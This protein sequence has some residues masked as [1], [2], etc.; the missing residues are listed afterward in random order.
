MVTSTNTTTYKKG[1]FYEINLN[2]LLADPRQPRK[3]MDAQG[4]E[5]LTAS[6]GRMGV[7]QPIVFRLDDQGNKVVVA[8][9]TGRSPKT[10]SSPL[11]KRSR[12]GA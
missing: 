12:P 10:P 11:P 7:V 9:G 3:S 8:G 5:E 4:L 1:K 2:E 6:V